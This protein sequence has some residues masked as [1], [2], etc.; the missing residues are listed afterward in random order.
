MATMRA[1]QVSRPDGPLDLVER[2]LP[3][4][5]SGEARVRIEACGICHSLTVEGTFPGIKYSIV[6][7]HE[8]AG[9][10][11]APGAGVVGWPGC[12]DDGPVRH[13]VPVGKQEHFKTAWLTDRWHF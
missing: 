1:V 8:I 3:E 2:P 9:R 10:I 12:P 11:E 6:P 7:G 5:G 4:P 13:C